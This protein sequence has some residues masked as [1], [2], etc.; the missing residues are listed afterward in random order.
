MRSSQDPNHPPRMLAASQKTTQ[1]GKNFV[2]LEGKKDIG[3]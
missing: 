2:S 1:D 3:C